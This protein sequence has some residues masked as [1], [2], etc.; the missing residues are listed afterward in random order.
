MNAISTAPGS[1]P[2]PFQPPTNGVPTPPFQ[3]GANPL[4]TPSK[5]LFF[6]PP[7]YI[8]PSPG[9]LGW[10]FDAYGSHLPLSMPDRQLTTNFKVGRRFRCFMSI[11]LNK[12]GR[13]KALEME[14]RWW[15]KLPRRLSGN[16]FEDYRR[17][18]DA[19]LDELA[20]ATGVKTL[21]IETGT[22]AAR[23]STSPAD[24][25]GEA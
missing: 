11:D 13:G 2:T 7:L 23:V 22:G 16:E 14:C 17:G 24:P 9:R 5:G 15:P 4:P 25:A 21:S 18:R 20:H 19:F 8:P 12:V 10:L 6:Q 1:L 3:R